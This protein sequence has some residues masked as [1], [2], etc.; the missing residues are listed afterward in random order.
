MNDDSSPEQIL[1]AIK[2]ATGLQNL[3]YSADSSSNTL[4]IIFGDDKALKSESISRK[5]EVALTN[6]DSEFDEIVLITSKN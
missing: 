4:Y 1:D 3:K 5:I 2:S 6:L